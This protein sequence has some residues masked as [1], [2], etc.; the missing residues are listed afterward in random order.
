[1][2]KARAD[3][4][5]EWLL[6]TTSGSFPAADPCDDCAH[7]ESD[8]GHRIAGGSWVED[9]SY[10]PAAQRLGDASDSTWYNVGIRCARA[11]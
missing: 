9:A 10:L 6:D 3:H 4:M 7:L 11:P 1:M 8:G 5:W 2:A